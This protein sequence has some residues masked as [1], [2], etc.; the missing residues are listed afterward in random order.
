MVPDD[1]SVPKFAIETSGME[2][3]EVRCCARV[4]ASGQQSGFTVGWAVGNDKLLVN[5]TIKGTV[6]L[7]ARSTISQVNQ[8]GSE[9][10]LFAACFRAQTAAQELL[11]PT[12][13]NLQ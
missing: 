6:T 12:E 4:T 5:P 13:P 9:G 2:A 7:V 3:L 11:S 8:S 1:Q 10:Q